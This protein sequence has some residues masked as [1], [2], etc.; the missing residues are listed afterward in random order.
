MPEKRKR[1]VVL[2]SQL[3][4]LK[5]KEELDIRRVIESGL[6]APTV[7]IGDSSVLLFAIQRRSAKLVFTSPPYCLDKPKNYGGPKP[8]EYVNWMLG[9]LNG[10]DHVL[11]DD[12]FL[13]LN[14]SSGSSGGHQMTQHLEV[15]V[16]INNDPRFGLI[17]DYIWHKKNCASGYWAKRLSSAAES[18]F[19]FSRKG[20]K[21]KINRDRMLVP[22]GTWRKKRLLGKPSKNDAVRLPSASGS[23]FSKCIN[24][25]KTGIDGC[26]TV[27]VAY[28]TNVIELATSCSDKKHSATYPGLLA[29]W[30]IKLTTQPGDLVVDPFVGSGTTCEA[31]AVLG[32]K[33][34]GIDNIK[35]PRLSSI[36]GLSGDA[37]AMA[38]VRDDNATRRIADINRELEHVKQLDSESGM[39]PSVRSYNIAITKAT[40]AND[41]EASQSDQMRVPAAQLAS[42]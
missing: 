41:V 23:N 42:V 4:D 6:P 11:S 33:S 7:L 27:E 3:M 19:L 15:I 16:A 13:A 35:H 14:I 21:T 25:W 24:N 34:I 29:E 10:I 36:I 39:Y 40:L 30:F 32:R 8:K 38:S 20:A 31:A 22:Q 12:G 2:Y 9:F 28:P 18:I 37:T 26:P 17:E 5:Q 1:I